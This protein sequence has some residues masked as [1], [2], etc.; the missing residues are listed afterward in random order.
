MAVRLT[1][2]AARAGVHPATASRALNADT[3]GLVSAAT[4]ARV[5]RAAVELNYVPNPIAKSLKTSRSMTIGVVIPDLTNPLFPPI[6]RG[7]EDV[8]SRHGYSALVVNTDNDSA[9]EELQIRG[10]RSRQVDG[11]II[12]TARQN[13]PAEPEMYR[14]VPRVYVIR[15]PRAAQASVVAGNDAVGIE[16]LVEHLVGLGH[17]HIGHVAGPQDVSAGLIRAQAFVAALRTRGLPVDDGAIEV[18]EEFLEAPGEVAAERLL[19]R[20]PEITAVVAANDLLALGVYDVLERRGLACPQDLSVTGFNDMPFIDRVAPPMTTVKVP[21]YA[22]GAEA[23]EL[24]FEAV[25][26][27]ASHVPRSVLLPVELTV[28]GSTAAPRQP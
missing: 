19:D 12:S 24:L 2:V 27:A 23:A 28:R 3:R 21:H 15:V 6:I 4:L 10:L 18:A 7:I 20:R 16:L 11:L 14:D 26:Q 25:A 17:R 8:A 22:I 5:Q 9:R 1:D 13:V